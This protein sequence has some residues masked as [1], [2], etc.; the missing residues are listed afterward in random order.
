MRI[1]RYYL[2]YI[3]FAR[4]CSHS[5]D[6]IP[7]LGGGRGK[8]HQRVVQWPNPE[9]L[10]IVTAT[11]DLLLPFYAETKKEVAEVAEEGDICLGLVQR[12]FVSD[13]IP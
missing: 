10:D 7:H 2:P 11:V 9:Q 6:I 4:L 1:K 13:V 12:Q 5:K 3:E 8:F